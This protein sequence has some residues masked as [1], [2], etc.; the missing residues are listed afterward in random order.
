MGLLSLSLSSFFSQSSQL[1]R[2]RRSVHKAKN[3]GS[4]C[5][6]ADRNQLLVLLI[7]FILHH[8]N[9][10]LCHMCMWKKRWRTNQKWKTD[11]V[12][13]MNGMK[14]YVCDNG[15]EQQRC[16]RVTRMSEQHSQVWWHMNEQREK[17]RQGNKDCVATICFAN[18]SRLT[19][20]AIIS[21]R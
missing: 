8:S 10:Y 4:C 20:L 21:E 2:P 12:K 7:S 15:R 17:Q 1:F 3:R 13:Q 5:E 6:I 16:R 18:V 9:H 14:Q 19:G 11:L